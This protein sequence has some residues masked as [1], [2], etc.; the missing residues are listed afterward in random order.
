[1][2][3][4]CCRPDGNVNVCTGIVDLDGPPARGPP[5]TGSMTPNPDLYTLVSA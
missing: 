3:Q 5:V 2:P 1:M 4:S